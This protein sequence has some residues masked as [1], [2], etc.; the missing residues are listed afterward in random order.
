MINLVW[1][2]YPLGFSPF[3]CG[4]HGP[5]Y[6][7][8]TPL[9]CWPSLVWCYPVPGMSSSSRLSDPPLCIGHLGPPSDDPWRGGNSPSGLPSCRDPTSLADR[10]VL[11][12]SIGLRTEP[13]FRG[14]P[15]CQPDLRS[16]PFGPLGCRGDVTRPVWRHLSSASPV[17]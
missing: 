11:P 17:S 14:G 10:G 9:L 1:W 2:Q 8:P 13:Y 7:F 15:L 5:N 4:A 6:H 12:L 3:G 16:F